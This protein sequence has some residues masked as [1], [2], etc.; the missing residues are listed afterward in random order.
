MSQF[1]LNKEL[2]E[3]VK[4]ALTE[5]Q[6]L[7]NSNNNNN[8]NNDQTDNKITLEDESAKY[9]DFFQDNNAIK[10]KKVG[11]Q[12]TTTC[13]K[14]KNFLSN[15]SY[16][17]IRKADFFNVNFVFDIYSLITKNLNPFSLEKKLSDQNKHEM[18]YMVWK[19]CMPSAF[20]KHVCSKDNFLYLNSENVLY[21][22]VSE[23]INDF[24]DADEQNYVLLRNNLSQFKNIFQYMYSNAYPE[25][26]CSTETMGFD[27]KSTFHIVFKACKDK[28]KVVNPQNYV[29][30]KNE[31]CTFEQKPIEIDVFN[32]EEEKEVKEKVEKRKLK[33]REVAK[34]N[35]LLKKKKKPN[36]TKKLKKKCGI[37]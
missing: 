16:V 35:K 30:E 2:D 11:K 23:I 14:L 10:R 25:I 9:P 19:E 12:Y 15:I 34:K 1:S 37:S 5:E 36:R 28:T 27:L 32:E 4:V 24:L 33:R 20:Y 17:G 6:M 29:Q 26:Y 7:G 18:I 8:K 13:I 21:P 3:L 31:T 22:K